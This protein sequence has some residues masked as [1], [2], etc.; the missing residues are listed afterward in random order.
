M[1]SSMTPSCCHDPEHD[2][3]AAGSKPEVTLRPTV[4]EDSMLIFELYAS[5]RVEELA[6][7]GWATPQQRSFLRLQAQNR[8]AH[9]GRTHHHLDSQTVCIDGFAAG[10]LLVDRDEHRFQVVDICL[11]PA[12]RNQGIGTGLLLDLLDQ[13]SLQQVVVCV[14]VLKDGRELGLCER[15]GFG[16]R[17]D[18]DTRW[19]LTWRPALRPGIQPR[20][21]G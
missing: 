6:R 8:E 10:R 14:D 18:L 3:E 9:L 13:A 7:T 20:R 4:P 12:Y 19:R 21:H 1:T 5:A 17:L 15:L 11:L 2:H 16:E